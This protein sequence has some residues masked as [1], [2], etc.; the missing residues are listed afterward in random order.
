MKKI[1]INLM[2]YDWIAIPVLF[3]N[4][5][6]TFFVEEWHREVT[7]PGR[8]AELFKTTPDS[9]FQMKGLY[10]ILGILGVIL[11]FVML[12]G[13]LIM[14]SLYFLIAVLL[15]YGVTVFLGIFVVKRRD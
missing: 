8:W 2:T 4:M 1:L 6:R 11:G 10:I 12:P 9:V 13:W 15:L 5:L 3:V 7:L 14:G